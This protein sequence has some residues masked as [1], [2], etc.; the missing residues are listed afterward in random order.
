MNDYEDYEEIRNGLGIYRVTEE[1]CENMKKDFLNKI[2][3]QCG[4]QVVYL[5]QDGRCS[6]CT[7]MT[8][9]EVI[10]EFL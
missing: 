5:F 10:G 3:Y 1:D 2:C 6:F 7:R 8:P 9:E 4:E